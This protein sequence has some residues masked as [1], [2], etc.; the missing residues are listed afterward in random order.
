MKGIII[1]FVL[2]VAIKVHG[3]SIE[4][5]STAEKDQVMAVLLNEKKK[6]VRNFN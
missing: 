5:Q 2:C 6:I 3:S 1:L 4:I